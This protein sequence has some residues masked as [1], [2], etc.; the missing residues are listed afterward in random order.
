MN[1]VFLAPE[2]LQRLGGG[3]AYVSHAKYSIPGAER[4][5]KQQK[6]CRYIFKEFAYIR[7]N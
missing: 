6:I 2:F 3:T 5:T 7:Y 1:I 4:M